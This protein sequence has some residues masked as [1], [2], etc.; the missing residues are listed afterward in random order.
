MNFRKLRYFCCIAEEGSFS[1]A[2]E[3]L[4]VAQPAL[5]RQMVELE[6]EVGTTLLNRLSRGVSL[7][8]AGKTFL[9]DAGKLLQDF[10]SATERA[11]RAA[12]GKIG[13]LNIGLIEYFSWHKAVVQPVRLYREEHRDV[14]LQLSTWERSSEILDRVLNEELD[15]GFTFNRSREDKHM[16][17]MPVFSVD[18][19]LAVPADYHL[20]RRPSIE[21][22][23]LALEPFVW[24]PRE[25]SSRH[26]DR[27]LM[28][29]NQAGFSPNI[30]QTATTESGR[31]S[32]VAAGVGCAIVTSAS[33]MWK[34]EQVALVKFSDVSLK[35]D[36]ELVWRAE[37]PSPTLTNFISAVELSTTLR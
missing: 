23:E 37:S 13:N 35:I 6:E 3:K 34:P 30:A 4:F 32:L 36:L 9:K 31:L 28:L 22:K 2:A 12:E 18:F 7:T 27:C 24:F 1:K 21:M 15:C 25:V 33:A 8:A 20:A 14:A 29:C 11:H 19:L 16:K 10:E 17:G 5:S 26:F